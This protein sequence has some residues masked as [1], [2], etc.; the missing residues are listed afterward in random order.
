MYIGYKFLIDYIESRKKSL[1]ILE[2]LS[3][4][5]VERVFRCPQIVRQLFN[6]RLNNFKRA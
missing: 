1:Y 4:N 5:V 2:T 3:V 6:Y